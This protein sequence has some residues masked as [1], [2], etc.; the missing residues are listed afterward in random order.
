MVLANSNRHV[1]DMVELRKHIEK[2][3]IEMVSIFVV[4]V[5]IVIQNKMPVSMFH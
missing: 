5:V 4:G 3:Q 1:W 2:T